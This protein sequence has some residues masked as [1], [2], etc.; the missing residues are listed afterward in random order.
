M[1]PPMKPLAPGLPLP[2]G[3]G[4]MLGT[5]VGGSGV[6]VMDG[7]CG[8]GGGVAGGVGLVDGGGV[9]FEVTVTAGPSSFAGFPCASAANFTCQEPT[10]KVVDTANVP[11]EDV[12]ATTL[13]GSVRFAMEAV[14]LAG[15]P[16]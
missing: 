5:G 15:A 4:V 3:L 1:N 7:G 16:S 13:M 9:A 10:G 11:F 12:P 14:T 8:V 6:A 2:T